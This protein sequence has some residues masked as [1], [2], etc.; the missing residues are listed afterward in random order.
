MSA[1]RRHLGEVATGNRNAKLEALRRD[2]VAALARWADRV[3][4]RERGKAAEAVDERGDALFARRAGQRSRVDRHEDL[5]DRAAEQGKPARVHG[6]RLHRPHLVVEVGA[7]EAHRQQRYDQR[8]A[9]ALRAAEREQAARQR[10]VSVGRRTS[11]GIDG[12]PGRQHVAALRGVTHLAPRQRAGRH[13]QDD[14]S[15]ATRRDS[16]G[17]R[18]GAEQRL[19][20][21][22]RG[23]RLRRIG[24]HDR[25]QSLG[26]RAARVIARGA[27]VG[28]VFEAHQS[29]PLGLRD[30]SRL[31][32]GV[33]RRRWAD[34]SPRVDASRDRRRGDRRQAVRSAREAAIDTQHVVARPDE[35]MSVLASEAGVDEHVAH[36]LRV[37][38]SK[39]DPRAALPDDVGERRGVDP[40]RILHRR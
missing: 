25:D 40:A 34:R 37:S 39:S 31:V 16:H 30:L 14:L 11:L 27:E 7:R 22:V 18:I 15:L 4:A 21:P 6:P 9:G 23:D 13:V 12:G 3:E 28:G 33:R 17:E 29:D 32:H 2:C 8:Q 20:G 36:R 10:R 5:S 24:Q 19:G 1:H 26:G 38:G 35:P